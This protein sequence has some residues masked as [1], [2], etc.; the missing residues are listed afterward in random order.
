MPKSLALTGFGK[1]NYDEVMGRP[2]RA[3]EGGLLYHVSN[4]A[5]GGLPIF[6]TA[7]DY[8]L[9]LRVLNDAR[10]RRPMRTLAYCLLPD[11]FRLVV[12]PEA[13]GELSEFVR[14]LTLTHTQRWHS[15][16]KSIGAGHL[17][18][19]RYRSFPIQHDHHL[20]TVIRHV[21]RSPVDAG[22]VDQAESWRWG[23]LARYTSA[24]MGVPGLDLTPWPVARPRQWRKLVN[25]P[26]PADEAEAV[27]RSVRRNQPCGDPAWQAATATRLG[28]ESTLRPVGR[29]RKVNPDA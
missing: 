9:F 4:H 18:G 27:A 14:W 21:E 1:A 12:W 17:Y 22:L 13:D 28:I 6:E 8:E 16:R 26:L 2:L 15:G 10:A 11:R 5:N 25:T 3:A 20:W 29:P 24:L 23:S 7:D 19:G